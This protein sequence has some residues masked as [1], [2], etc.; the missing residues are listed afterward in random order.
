MPWAVHGQRQAPPGPT[1]ARPGVPRSSRVGHDL[2]GQGE[3]STPPAG[4]YL[5]LGDLL[6][7]GR[8]STLSR[9][10]CRSQ[11]GAAVGVGVGAPLHLVLAQS[12]PMRVMFAL[13]RV[14]STTG[15][16]LSVW[17]APADQQCRGRIVCFIA[18]APVMT[19]LNWGVE[20]QAIDGSVDLAGCAALI[21]AVTFTASK[22]TPPTTACYATI[23]RIVA[24]V[25]RAL[26]VAALEP[27][28]VAAP[29]PGDDCRLKCDPRRQPL[30]EPEARHNGLSPA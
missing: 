23:E 30:A 6:H 11:L 14:R 1:G 28:E 10:I 21:L 29:A 5:G 12:R 8:G 27:R 3:S 17:S 15:A 9:Y 7:A 22:N 20:A 18:D 26:P 16:G 25:A 24:A 19:Q 4:Q 2:V 13:R